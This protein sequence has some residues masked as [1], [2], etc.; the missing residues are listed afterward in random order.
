MR[1]QCCPLVEGLR[2]RDMRT[3]TK[4]RKGLDKFIFKFQVTGLERHGWM[5]GVKGAWISEREKEAWP[6]S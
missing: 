3:E 4:R 1:P 6:C 2:G 5:K